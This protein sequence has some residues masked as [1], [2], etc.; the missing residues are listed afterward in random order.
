LS[1]ALV[2]ESDPDAK[3]RRV[4]VWFVPTSGQLPPSLK[5]YKEA[6]SLSVASLGCPK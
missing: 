4:E 3:Y 1:G 5:D 6:A 2:N